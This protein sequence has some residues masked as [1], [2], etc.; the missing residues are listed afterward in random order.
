MGEQR[1]AEQPAVELAC[2]TSI[3]AAVGKKGQALTSANWKVAVNFL[4][5]VDNAHMT[6]EV[7]DGFD[8]DGNALGAGQGQ[9]KIWTIHAQ[10]CWMEGT[11]PPSSR[12]NQKA[13]GPANDP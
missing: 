8:A 12:M 1:V 10:N 7:K 13:P 3:Q 4:T 9:L 5:Q 11:C 6:V 2:G